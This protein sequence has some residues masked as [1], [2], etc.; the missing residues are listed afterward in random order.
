MKC[1]FLLFG[2]M[3]SSGIMLLSTSS[4]ACFSVAEKKTSDL[5]LV[6]LDLICIIR[7]NWAKWM[8][9]ST[10]AWC[11]SCLVWKLKKLSSV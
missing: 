7:L 4:L 8:F 10:V 11:S 3:S 5:D 2:K 9:R 6:V 1:T